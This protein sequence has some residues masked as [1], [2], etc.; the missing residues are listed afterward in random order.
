MA[1]NEID[2][3][4]LTLN[5]KELDP[6][7]ITLPYKFKPR[8]YE[9]DVWEAFDRGIKRL[10]LIWHR[11]AGKD[12]TAWN[13]MINQAISK[14]GNNYYYIFP[15]YTEA[16]RNVW[17]AQA[18]LSG[19]DES[20]SFLDH[21]PEQL[22][23][24]IDKEALQITL[25]N[26][27]RIKL[28]Q[29]EDFK[30]LRGSN[31]SGVV[32]SEFQLAH[33]QVWPLVFSPILRENGGWALFNFT[34]LGKNHAWKLWQNTKADPK[35]FW[36][37]K[38]IRD[39]FFAD[40]RRVFTEQDLAEARTEMEEWQ[41]QQ[42]LFN[43]F[44]GVIEGN[45]YGK[46]LTELIKNKQIGKFP[47]D[48]RYPVYTTWDLGQNDA[49][50]IWFYQK[51]DRRPV[52]IDYYE[53]NGEGAEFYLDVLNSRPYRFVKHYLPHDADARRGYVST[54]SFYRVM[55]ELTGNRD[56]FT[57]VRKASIK[58]GIQ[59]VRSFLPTCCFNEETT[60]AG[61]DCLANYHRE[62]DH[63]NNT[64]KDHP[65]HDWSSNGADS[66]R[67][68]AMSYE[69]IPLPLPS[70]FIDPYSFEFLNRGNR[71]SGDGGSVDWMGC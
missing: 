59:A 47:H 53:N 30:K 40:G 70:D 56:L 62:K 14:P 26:G 51:I 4:V 10:G 44:D 23:E 24:K 38:T 60:E 17:E 29:A 65:Q 71:F 32:F 5:E 68:A 45:Y 35:W 7:E 55:E 66:F 21:I 9:W 3:T 41:V 63:K 67:Y 28:E 1:K 27:S 12:R 58:T 25:T 39:T 19:E 31:P 20:T 42:E 11:R 33:H 36:S 52:F 13:F 18:N 43:S 46:L 48:A 8:P 57:I 50:A 69:E 49:T 16:R 34:A 22:I 6:I 37:N 61:L 2:S 64:F 54:K 15:Q